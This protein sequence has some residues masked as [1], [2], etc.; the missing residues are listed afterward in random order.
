MSHENSLFLG[1]VLLA[2]SLCIWITVSQEK[3]P[4]HALLISN[5]EDDV[6]SILLAIVSAIASWLLFYFYNPTMEMR[7]A[8][9]AGYV[10]LFALAYMFSA[11]KFAY[12]QE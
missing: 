2:F 7:G 11:S 8:L 1:S 3:S 6:F 10:L 12:K 9:T 4:L 5:N